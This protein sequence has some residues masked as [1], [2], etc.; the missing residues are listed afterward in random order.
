MIKDTA[1]ALDVV[2]KWKTASME[3]RSWATKELMQKGSIV[4]M[5]YGML[6]LNQA[7]LA[8]SGSDQKINF[9]DPKKGDF[10]QFK[11]AG[12]KVGVASPLIGMVRLVANALHASVLERTKFE[13]LTPRQKQLME[14]AGQY[15]RGKA[16]PLA[17]FGID[18]ATAQDFAHRPIGFLPWSEPLSRKQ[19]LSGEHPYG[20]GEYASTTFAPIPL[21]EMMKNVFKQEGM[22][23]MDAS[24][25]L[26]TLIIGG[27]M[28][29]TGARITEDQK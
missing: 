4:A 16:S 7:F 18:A 17:S 2:R 8:M 25:L 9:T 14:V 19:R 1:K 15:A 11:V 6:G 5:Y 28:S 24:K 22:N 13:K 10:M 29:A 12:F 23:E 27:G 21:E 20:V 26:R 3:Q